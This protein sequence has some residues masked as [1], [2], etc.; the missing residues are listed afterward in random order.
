[1]DIPEGR[2]ESLFWIIFVSYQW[3]WKIEAWRA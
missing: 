2:E 3:G 1:M